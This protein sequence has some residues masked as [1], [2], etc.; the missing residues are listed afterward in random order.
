M[1]PTCGV[2]ATDLGASPCPSLAA[3]TLAWRLLHVRGEKGLRRQGSTVDQ[4]FNCNMRAEHKIRWPHTTWTRSRTGRRDVPPELGGRVVTSEEIDVRRQWPVRRR[5]SG[6]YSS[7]T[8]SW[9]ASCDG[10]VRTPAV[11][12][13]SAGDAIACRN[14]CARLGYPFI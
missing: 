3:D 12:L 4:L 7:R 6:D 8:W 2:C 9:K 11:A 5:G 1:L 10:D 14:L 13:A